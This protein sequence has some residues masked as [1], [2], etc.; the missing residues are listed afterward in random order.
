M[1]LVRWHVK[2]FRESSTSWFLSDI[3]V[4]SQLVVEPDASHAA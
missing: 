3:L 4:T 1:E 2:H